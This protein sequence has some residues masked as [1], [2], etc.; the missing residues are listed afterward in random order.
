MNYLK[1]KRNKIHLFLIACTCFA[2]LVQAHEIRPAYL[3]ITEDSNHTVTVLWKQP[4]AGEVGVK[5]VPHLSSGWLEKEPAEISGSHSFIIK[6]WIIKNDKLPIAGQKIT[7]EGLDQTITDVLVNISLA[8]GK[9][10]SQ[11][12]RPADPTY[13][14]SIAAKP[15][16]VISYMFL[17]IEHILEGIDHLLFVL[18]FLLLVADKKRLFKAITAFT[19][20]HSITL[21]AATMHWITFQPA[22][23]ETIIALSIVFMAVELVHSYQGRPGLTAKYP[24]IIAFTFGLLHGFGFAGALADIGLPEQALP[25]ALFLFNVGVEI[26]QLIFV[27]GVL[28]ILWAIQKSAIPKTGIVKWIA[29]Y[30]IGTFSSVWFIERLVTVI[31]H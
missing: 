4:I 26:G 29:P 3:G 7:I 28:A 20:A 6:K 23:I 24:W 27:G 9:N 25:L 22:V 18:G 19:V 21:T 14:I 15:L 31:F 11:I 2:T 17:G 8:N 12:I 13:A 30:A 16:Q 5:L 1:M 10:F